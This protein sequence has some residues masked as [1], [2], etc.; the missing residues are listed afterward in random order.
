MLRAV[1]KHFQQSAFRWAVL[2]LLATGLVSSLTADVAAQIELNDRP[3]RSISITFPTGSSS[4]ADEEEFHSIAEQ[5]VGDKYSVVRVRDS[6]EALHRTNKIISVDVEA[7]DTPQGI[8][9]R[10]DIK[11]KPL[12]QKVSIEL[13][14][15]NGEPVT[16]QELMFKLNLL[17]P[18]TPITD[19]TLQSNANVILE[20]LRDRGYF[21]A[22]VTFTQTPVQGGS[23]VGVVFHVKPNTQAKVET[24][25]VNIAGADNAKIR[26]D[27]KLQPGEPYS[28]DRLNTDVDK[29][30]ADLREASFLAP[31]LDEPGVV[32]DSEKNAINIDIKGSVGPTVT[33]KV[34]AGKESIKSKATQE[35]LIP[36]LSQGTLDYS[37]I[38][39]GERRLENF[40]QEKGFF[41]ANV[42][43]KCSV[44]PPFTE[45]EASAVTNNTEFLCSALGS[46]E[47]TNRKVEVVYE[48][49]LNR[50]LNLSEIR[51]QGTTQFTIDDIRP[52]LESQVS[53]IL[54]FIPIFGYGH[55]LTS[56]RLLDQDAATIKSLLS[57]LGYRDAQVR[58]NQGV[59]PAGNDLII[60]FVVDEGR[61]T[62]VSDVEFVGN[63]AID[64]ARLRSTIGDFVG[65]NYS[66][67]RLRVAQQKLATLYSEEGYFDARVT[68]GETFA[69]APPDAP[70]KT[71][72]IT[73]TVENEGK[74]VVVNRVLV[75]GNVDTHPNAILRAVTIKPNDLLKRTDIYT[76]EQNLYSTDVFSRVDIKPQA[77]GPGPNNTRLSDVIVAVEEQAPRL[78][79]YGGG[80]STDLGANGFFDIRHFNLLGNLWQGGARIRWSQ[81]QQL[82]QFDFID[83]RFMRDGEKR[84]APL[85]ITAE[86][87][88]DSTVT[89]FFRSAFDRGTFGIV[90]RIDANGNPV[91]EFGNRVANPTINRLTFTAETNR[92]ISLRQ[93]AVVFL[94]YRYED[95]RLFNIYSLLIKDL[96]LPDQ[97]VR[98]SGFGLT[99]VR[100]TREKCTIKYSILE[101]IARGEPGDKCRYDAADPTRG[102][103]LT[104]EYNMS[105]PALGAN[106][107][108]QK[109]QLS[110]NYYYSFPQFRNAT[111]AARG[112][113]GLAN[114]FAR[115]NRFS[116]S[117]F[118]GLEGVL[119]ISER[120]FAG[121]AYTL[122]GFAFEEAGPRVVVVPQWTFHDTKGN[123]VTLD[124]FTVPFGGNALAVV[125]IEGRI[126]LSDSIRAVPFYDG[127][128]VFRRVGDLFNPPNAP[129]NDAFTANLRAVWSHT[130]GLGLRI[131][132]PIGGEFGV[133][134]G[135]L[136]NPPRFLV[137]QAVGPDAIYQLPRHQL[138][139]RFSQAF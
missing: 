110:Y 129:A 48:T 43:P 115:G 68:T 124:P 91:D 40:Y 108:F 55:G 45:D 60:T 130:V 81:Q 15:A 50:R 57:E 80:Y 99:F 14:D 31:E 28:R 107:G 6:I 93:R 54:G 76:S 25:N 136:L 126:P 53:N 2:W 22:E 100:D 131:K 101:T 36:I 33:I 98:I 111:I 84:F 10:Y 29:V 26:S 104:A 30:R 134:Y 125:N 42:T 97:K 122:R 86:Y 9:L 117:Q 83:P 24:L 72:K 133:D 82:I 17:D 95:V 18:G 77:A 103:Y 135:W 11:R 116:S 49:D 114:V 32:F 87:Q 69:D 37:A 74:K 88:R 23:G 96:L 12:A 121:G 51:L 89:R 109:F 67:A 128:N 123:P 58:V 105:A 73:F 106:I 71:V 8:D 56:Q 132:T 35:K 119:P 64:S 61:P 66:R 46:A 5:T 75:T 94:R 113:L 7:S 112:I 78:M 13:Q 4:Q 90:Q 138:H 120:F 44:T 34:D 1:R 59:S 41:F 20:Y 62:V 139:F 52:A 3:I 102:D 47:L 65:Q 39:E 63:K 127:G 137:P 16:E 21:N 79:Q 19:Q 92:T 38:V 118:P 85:T 27:L 70:Q